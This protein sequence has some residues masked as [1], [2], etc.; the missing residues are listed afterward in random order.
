MEYNDYRPAPF[1]PS[2][3][4]DS[5]ILTAARDRWMNVYPKYLTTDVAARGRLAQFSRG[6]PGIRD[7]EQREEILLY[8]LLVAAEGRWESDL[9]SIQMVEPEHYPRFF[10]DYPSDPAQVRAVFDYACQA[11]R[12]ILFAHSQALGSLCQGPTERVPQALYSEDALYWATREESFGCFV[13]EYCQLRS[14]GLKDPIYIK[15]RV[16]SAIICRSACLLTF[17]SQPGDIF[18]LTYEQLLMIRDALL[19]RK[20]A[21]IACHLLYNQDVVLPKLCKAVYS[22]QEQCLLELGNVGYEIAKSVESLSKAYLS[23]AARDPLTGS[24]D[25]FALMIAKVTKKENSIYQ[26]QYTPRRRWASLAELF[27]SRVLV[28]CENIQHVAECFGLQK[29]SGHPLIDPRLGG[30]TSAEKARTP[31]TTLPSSARL[32]RATFCRLFTETFI[33]K[34]HRWPSLIFHYHGTLL[35]KLYTSQQLRVHRRSYPLSDWDAV[36]FAKEFDFEYYDNYLELMDD[37]AISLYRDEKHMQWDSGTPRSQRRLLLELLSRDTFSIYDIVQIIENDEIPLSWKICSLYPKEREFKL[38]ARMFTMLVMEMRAFFAC[39]EANIATTVLPYFPQITMVDDKLTIHERFLALTRPM[40]SPD[41]VRLFLELDLSSWNLMWREL[42]I[43]SIGQDLNDLFGLHKVFTTAHKFFSESCIMVRVANLRPP[44]IEELF[45]P[46]DDLCWSG[47][48]GGFEGIIQKLW[49]IATVAMIEVALTD[50]DLSYSITDQGDNI[51]VVI[52]T[53]R[54]YSVPLND[55]LHALEVMILARCEAA[56]A[57][58]HQEL[59]PEE[60]L[61]SSTTITYSKAVYVNGVDYPTSLKA[62]SR[63]HPTSAVDFP[64]YSS[65]IQSIFSGAVAASETAKRPEK[66]YWAA[67]LQAGLFITRTI[68]YGGAY[69]RVLSSIHTLRDPVAIRLQLLCPPE[70]GG[71]PILGPY[72]FLYKGGGDPLSK[73]LASLFILQ[74]FLPEARWIIG[75][76]REDD[77]FNRRPKM[78]NLIQDPYG[79]PIRKPPTPED[80]IAESTLGVVRSMTRNRE[81]RQT[82]DF[83]AAGYAEKMMEIVQ[84]LVPFNPVV[85]RDLIDCSALGTVDSIKR[86]FLKTRTLQAVS[87]KLSEENLVF[88]MLDAGTMQIFWMAKLILFIRQHHGRIISLYQYVEALRAR[89]APLGVTISGLTSYMPC[90]FNCSWDSRESAPAILIEFSRGIGNFLY[91]RG[92]SRAYLGSRTVEKRSEHGYKIVGKGPST[93]ALKSLQSILGWSS[94]TGDIVSFIDYLARSRCG[95]NLSDYTAMLAG[96]VGGDQGHRYA[97]RIGERDAHLLGSSTVASHVRLDSDHAGFLSATTEDYPIMFQEFFLYGISLS[98]YRAVTGTTG[99]FSRLSI[100]IGHSPLITLPQENFS[101]SAP[102]LPQEIPQGLRLV[103]SVGVQIQKTSGPLWD[104]AFH[105]YTPPARSMLFSAVVSEIARALGSARHTVGILDHVVTRISFRF[106]LQEIA[107]M[108][109]STFFQAAA[110]VLLDT[111]SGLIHSP[112]YGSRFSSSVSFINHRYGRLL[113]EGIQ[114]HLYHPLLAQDPIVQ[115]FNIGPSPSYDKRFPT[116]KVLVSYLATVAHQ[117]YSNPRSCYYK[118]P[119]VVFGSDVGEATLQHCIQ[120]LRRHACRALVSG[121]ISEEDANFI[122]GSTIRR[123]SRLGLHSE[124]DKLEVFRDLLLSYRIHRRGTELVDTSAALVAERVALCAPGARIY[125]TNAS[126]SEVLREYRYMPPVQIQRAAQYQ[127]EGSLTLTGYIGPSQAPD[128]SR[129]IT[130]THRVLFKFLTSVRNSYNLASGAAD[131]WRRLCP[132]FRGEIVVIVGSGLGGCASAAIAGG[133]FKVYGHDLR[134]DLPQDIRLEAYIPPLVR[135]FGS[136]SRYQ[137]SYESLETTGDWFDPTVSK[138][139]CQYQQT[140]YL[141][142]IDISSDKG[143]SYRVLQPAIDNRFPHRLLLRAQTSQHGHELIAGT[144]GAHGHLDACWEFHNFLGLIERIYLVRLTRQKWKYAITPQ[145]VY[146]ISRVTPSRGKQSLIYILACIIAPL[147]G[148]MSRTVRSSLKANLHSFHTLVGRDVSRPTY[149]EWTD[150]LQSA[151]ACEWLLSFS[152]AE[153][154][155]RLMQAEQH[156]TIAL[157][158][159]PDMLCLADE[160]CIHYLAGLVSRLISHL[161]DPISF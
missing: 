120:A 127:G 139:L 3:H 151:I 161:D 18:F 42:C 64:S 85:A 39:H 2:R 43:N 24:A 13:E 157:I 122:V 112:H 106:G 137:Q 124:V 91:S 65:Y 9:A 60:S 104:S 31:D 148:V 82:L 57:M 118:C 61:S 16:G 25:S 63:I 146:N 109:L 156:G 84:T 100:L 5:P 88:T 83:G 51:V 132:I 10:H 98:S 105:L 19:M 38:A 45:P 101:L 47:H 74:D 141:L 72:A 126:A 142:V 40:D 130:S 49:S 70:L 26:S 22:W 154:C 41:T 81:I 11:V 30:K 28:S 17:S 77:L 80:A 15:K 56:S 135:L 76:S 6:T 34:H 129:P 35:E 69:H 27:H 23:R 111:I 108:G 44:Q 153:Y 90:D 86:M 48:K 68:S 117:I 87:R 93:S 67:L 147:G 134:C 55:Q 58:M 96:V 33:R 160:K 53:P 29:F 73:S 121:I 92:P 62:L 150:V 136:T 46:E 59:K 95:Y 97:A 110:C 21:A 158:T 75:A 54:Q 113:V 144:I 140:P 152:E 143:F 8:S 103:Q 1:F 89:W 32:L 133:A 128:S 155:A 20:N 107:G 114:Q 12:P 94:Y 99:S 131:S 78:E 102:S 119:V 52:T 36:S 138:R 7:Y 125:A 79:L 71:L 116:T 37:K 66:C 50:L 115:R 123:M 159:H 14:T 149:Q 4:L 145:A